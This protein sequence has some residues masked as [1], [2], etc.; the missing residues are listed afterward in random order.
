LLSE[1]HTGRTEGSPQ[2]VT[3][4][5]SLTIITAKLCQSVITQFRRSVPK[6]WRRQQQAAFRQERHLSWQWHRVSHQS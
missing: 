2:L 1:Q 3:A 4:T 5:P 6:Y